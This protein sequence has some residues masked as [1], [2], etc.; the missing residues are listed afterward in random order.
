MKISRKVLNKAQYS[1]SVQS[2]LSYGNGRLVF[3]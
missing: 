3:S 1:E 2:M